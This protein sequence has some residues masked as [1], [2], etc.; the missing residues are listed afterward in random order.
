MGVRLLLANPEIAG[1]SC[2][3]CK[4]F[5]FHDTGERLSNK[6]VLR[7]DGQPME[8]PQAGRVYT[9]CR[10]CPKIPHGEE[11]APE[12][13]VELSD[14]NRAAYWHYL[15]CKGVGQWPD[16]PIVRRNAG[17]IRMVE[18]DVDRQQRDLVPL[19]LAMLKR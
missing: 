16:D 10:I 3:D 5:L 4:R 19:L 15:Q 7:G 9:P 8:R 18:D 1:R 13:A 14:K 12:N 2:E 6:K 17:I 11:P